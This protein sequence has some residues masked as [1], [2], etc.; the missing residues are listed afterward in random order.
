MEQVF[1]QIKGSNLYISLA[2]RID[3]SNASEIEKKIIGIKSSISGMK[4]IL[5]AEKLEYVS[6]AG[7][8]IILGLRKGDP[9]LKIIHVSDAVYD[10]LD[11]TGFTDIVTVEKAQ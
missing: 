4:T 3:A 10:I 9:T 2:G 1:F 7:L 6:S 11:M 5:D 8:R